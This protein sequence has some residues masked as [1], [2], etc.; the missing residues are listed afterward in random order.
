MGTATASLVHPR[1]VFQPAVGLGAC[2]V[3]VAH[4]HPSDD[5]RPSAED[6]EVTRRLVQAVI[7][8]AESS[9]NARDRFGP[10]QVVELFP[11]EQ[12]LRALLLDGCV[13]KKGA[14]TAGRACIS[15]FPI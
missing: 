14:A 6:R 12:P 2:A 7:R 1:E 11:G 4:N 13:S 9:R 10:D 3:I 15:G 5:P 8:Q